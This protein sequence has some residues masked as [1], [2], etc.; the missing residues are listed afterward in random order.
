MK[1][2]AVTGGIGAGKSTVVAMLA[3]LGAQIV[4][5]DQLAREVVD[6]ATPRGSDTLAKVRT[7]LGDEVFLDDGSIGRASVAEAIFSDDE[8]RAGYNRILFPAIEAATVERLAAIAEGDP[9]ATVAHEIPLYT[10]RALPWHYDYVVTVEADDAIRSERL[11]QTRGYTPAH[12]AERIRAQGPSA[13]REAIAD[14]VIRSDGSREQTQ[15]QVQGLWETV[16]TLPI[17]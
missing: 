11:V 17:G 14:L 3:Q 9:S 6:P 1:I 15:S 13:P 8:L 2:I 7:L 16:Q 5:G 10:G 4:D 12:A